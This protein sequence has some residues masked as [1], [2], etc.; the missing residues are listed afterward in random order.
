MGKLLSFLGLS[1]VAA[2][3]CA[4]LAAPA[5][6]QSVRWMRGYDAPGT[7]ERYDRVGVIEIGP[8][9]ARNVLVLSPGTS[10]GAAYF[11]PLAKSLVSRLPGW[12]VWSVERRENLLEDQSV[13]N[14]Y[15]AG[16]VSSKQ[17]FDYY[18]GWVTDSSITNHVQLIPDGQ[19]GFAR[20]WGMNVELHDLRDVVR[21][22][23]RRGGKVVLGGHSL[24]G[25]MT[26]AYATW[27]FAGQAGAKGLSGLVFIDGASR[28]Q[29]ISRHDAKEA[30]SNLQAGSPWLAFG[31]IGAPFAGIF[32]NVGSG[33]AYED[34]A[35]K[36][37]FDGLAALPPELKPPEPLTNEAALGYASDVETSPSSLLAFQAHDG[38]VAASGDPRPWDQAGEI[39][40]I[41]RYAKMLF[42][43]GVKSSDG[44]VWYHPLRLTIDAG[45]VANGNRNPA[46]SVLDVHATHGDDVN[47]PMYAFGAALGDGRVLRSVRALARQSGEP[48][49]ELTLVDRHA[50]YA[51]NDPN[52]AAPARNAFLKHLVPF[53]AGIAR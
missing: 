13:A 9:R 27:D 33:L 26:S 48:K 34:P 8:K 14:E 15:K 49:S 19:V 37:Q 17:F 38:R 20:D 50:T 10:A 39:T 43:V 5:G 47:V 7:P 4:T 40:P 36:S 51:H 30:L 24:G 44:A 11:V 45:A 29:P 46:Q 16:G 1:L 32:A 41:Q 21:A 31:G 22:A 25:T 28:P 42:G 23:K 18:L 12:Q 35:S 52:A 53:L 2:L 6:A 3:A